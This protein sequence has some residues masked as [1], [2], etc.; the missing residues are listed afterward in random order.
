M[1]ER[2]QQAGVDELLDRAL[3]AAAE[4]DRATA[5]LLAGQV[6]AVDRH[7]ADAEDLLTAPVG[8]GEIRRLTIAFVDLVDSTALSTRIEPETYR[9]VV[10]RY[11]DDVLRAVHQYEGH[12]GSTKGDGLLILFGHPE[13]HEDD[14]IRAV[15]AGLDITRDVSALSAQ[16][17]RQLGFD[18]AVRVGIHRGVVYLDR[19]QDDVYGLAANLAARVC[20]I[21]EPGTVAVSDA[22]EPLIRDHFEL[23][24]NSPQHVKGVDDPVH[25]YRVDTE[26][27]TTRVAFGPLVGRNSELDY[28]RQSWQQAQAGE[29]TRPGVAF[30]GDAGIGKSRLAWSAV[31]L[32][33]RS[34]AVVLQLNGSPFYT[35][36][37]L[38]P[39]RRL[40]ERRCGIS[41]HIRPGAASPFPD[42][43]IS[44]DAPSTRLP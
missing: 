21:A 16:V 36:V 6:L 10:G 12:V 1:S 22:I 31:D 38:R 13:A 34:G 24:A 26:R 33:E 42:G 7:N 5:H 11:R 39:I 14:V 28:L 41:Q 29:L 44:R 9:M 35:D 32:A 2:E 23:H 43:R 17:R 8:R 18:I 19:A 20:S 15:Q 25:S 27:E 30:V 4:G 40:L 3:K 37:G